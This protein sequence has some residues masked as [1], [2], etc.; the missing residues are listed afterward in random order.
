MEF[1][2][3]ND[4]LASA[5]CSVWGTSIDD[6]GLQTS[7]AQPLFN[8]EAKHKYTEN[9]SRVL[10]N[11]LGYLQAY[12]NRIIEKVNVNFELEFVGYEKEDPK[13]ILELDKMELETIKSLNEKREEKGLKAIDITKIKNPADLPM[14]QQIVQ[15]FTQSQGGMSGMEDSG[16]M[17]DMEGLGGGIDEEIPGDFGSEDDQGEEELPEKEGG[18]FGDSGEAPRKDD[19]NKSLHDKTKTIT[20]II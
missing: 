18:D 7:K 1:Q 20:I 9:K 17:G 16:E 3:W 2:Q 12:L 14:N 13:E 15:L 5:V 6:I 4:Y 8:G 19:I 10:G 11:I